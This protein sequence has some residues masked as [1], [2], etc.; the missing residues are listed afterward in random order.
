MSPEEVVRK[1]M[2]AFES[3]QYEQAGRFLADDMVLDGPASEP[4]GKDAFLALQANLYKGIPDW[5]FNLH[6]IR[7]Q[8]DMV[9][10]RVQITGTNS[11]PIPP[12]MPGMQPIPVTGKRVSLPEEG[13]RFTVREDK[14]VRIETDNTPGGG[15]AGLLGQLGTKIQ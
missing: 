15:V 10:A 2:Q 8:G 6:D 1:C 5:S 12:L 13:I 4:V 14:I 9:S 7:T 3:G 11:Q